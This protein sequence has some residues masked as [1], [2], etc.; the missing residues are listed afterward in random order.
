MRFGPPP[1]LHSSLLLTGA[2]PSNGGATFVG[3]L[4]DYEASVTSAWSVVRRLFT[5][6]E[7]PL[8]RL[9][10]VSDNAEQDFGA[11]ANGKLDKAAIA[12]FLTATTGR[13][14]T[15]YDHIASNDWTQATASRQPLYTA[16]LTEF[17]GAPSA[18]LGVDG[19]MTTA[20]S[21]T[22]PYSLALTECNP[23]A[24]IS[25]GL[26]T[27]DSNS[28]NNLIS[29]SRAG[30]GQCFVSGTVAPAINSADALVEILTAGSSGNFAFYSNATN[31]TTGSIAAANW[32]P[33]RLGASGIWGE[34]GRSY[35]A[36]MVAFNTAL[37]SGQVT[38]LQS[39]FDPSAL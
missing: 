4:D 36:E 20:L 15:I 32:G 30:A 7:G 21:L 14:T 19:G 27:V 23:D 8:I 34:P 10:R 6:Y 17:N 22:T 11:A 18:Y 35:L 33:P 29:S 13:V 28:G 25:Q 26:R 31:V 39:I 9:R 37:T 38:A 12:T 2:G 16:S 3:P 1:A 5:S 24:I